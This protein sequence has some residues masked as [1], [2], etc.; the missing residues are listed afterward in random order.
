MLPV[1]SSAVAA[2][3]RTSAQV[4]LV[5]QINFLFLFAVRAL[6][7]QGWA[8]TGPQ[9]AASAGC[10]WV[11]QSCPALQHQ[12]CSGC[13]GISLWPL[14][15]SVSEHLNFWT[16]LSEGSDRWDTKSWKRTSSETNSHILQV[17]ALFYQTPSLIPSFF[18]FYRGSYH[19]IHPSG[20]RWKEK[21]LH[22]NITASIWSCAK[23]QRELGISRGGLSP[24]DISKAVPFAPAPSPVEAEQ[25]GTP[26]ALK[27]SSTN[28]RKWI[29]IRRLRIPD[30]AA[31]WALC[32][33]SYSLQPARITIMLIFVNSTCSSWQV[34]GE[35]YPTLVCGAII[36]LSVTHKRN[37]KIPWPAKLFIYWIS[38][39]ILKYT[40]NQIYQKVV[41]ILVKTGSDKHVK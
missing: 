19:V 12:V 23:E 2:W 1:P 36:E 34:E 20:R 13:G 30:D 18:L 11:S 10:D 14:A 32:I 17:T 24:T 27:A 16:V 41:S 7:F 38:T 31:S 15:A 26:A 37:L 8:F 6:L 28:I 9:A 35:A 29:K 3:L 33:I 21:E 40:K 5:C 22:S 4:H 39:K 25:P